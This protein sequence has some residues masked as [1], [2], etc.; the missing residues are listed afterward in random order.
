M[1]TDVTSRQTDQTTNWDIDRDDSGWLTIIQ[2]VPDIGALEVLKRNDTLSGPVKLM[3]GV[4]GT[5]Q[6]ADVFLGGDRLLQ[7]DPMLDEE[8]YEESNELMDELLDR[9]SCWFGNQRGL[10]EWSPPEPKALADLLAEVGHESAIDSD[11]NLRLAI[12]RRGCDGQVRIIRG[13]GRLRFAMPFGSWRRL[14]E[15]TESAMVRLAAQANSRSRL[16]RIAWRDEEDR[17]HVEAQV[18]LTGLPVA[19]NPSSAAATMWKE[20]ICMTLSALELLLRRLGLELPLLADA[21]YPELIDWMSVD[22][23]AIHKTRRKKKPR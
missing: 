3:E 17:Q 1:A 13:Q 19:E 20:T 2:P 7:N 22:Q 4:E 8:A 14:D 6:R 10:D 15:A 9:A 16:A 21:K 5:V 18:D 11:G 23:E 12:K